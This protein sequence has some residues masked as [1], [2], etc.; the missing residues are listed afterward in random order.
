[1][2]S[3]LS[4]D[5]EFLR[6][7]YDNRRVIFVVL[8]TLPFVVGWWWN[9]RAKKWLEERG[10]LAPEQSALG[11]LLGSQE[12]SPKPTPLRYSEQEFR[13]IVSKVL[14]ELPKEF[15]KEWKNVAVIVSTAWPRDDK[16]KIGVPEGHSVLGTY[17]GHPKTVG[18]QSDHYGHVV[19]IY[20]PALESLCGSDKE[21]LEREVRRTVL[22]ELG[23]HLGMSHKRMREVGL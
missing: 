19:T 11:S 7:P 6:F 15:D 20:Q 18:L 2:F 12:Q 8:L 3:Q 14:D 17:W 1:M 21:R 23:H 10:R 4:D 5:H 22:H 9:R 16:K 13:E